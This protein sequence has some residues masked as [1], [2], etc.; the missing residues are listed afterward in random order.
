[1]QID[2]YR[3]ADLA[4]LVPMWRAAF[5]QGVGIVDTHPLAD[6]AAYFEREVLPHHEVLVARG[7]DGSMLGFVACNAESIAQL[8]VRVGHHR[9]GIGSRLVAL[10]KERSAGSLWLYTFARNVNARR[11]YE[12]HGF[13]ATAFGF[14]PVW[15]LDDVR[16]EWRPAGPQ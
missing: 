4:E 3:T 15:Q 2:P 16:Y 8:H 6:Q 10:A 7:D 9:Q 14:E 5:E 1:M 13:V 12:H 11:F